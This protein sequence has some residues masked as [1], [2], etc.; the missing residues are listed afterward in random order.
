MSKMISSILPCITRPFRLLTC[1]FLGTGSIQAAE[2]PNIVFILCDDLGY[3]DVGV[4]HQNQRA[5][6]NDRSVP[7]FTT[8]QLDRM[9]GGGMMLTQHYCGA[10][11]CAPSRAT[12]LTGLT[13][14]HANIRDNQFDKALADTH[15]VGTVLRQAGYAT[16]AIGKWGLQG[17]SSDKPAA[18]KPGKGG[19]DNKKAASTGTA[20][21]WPAYPTRRGFDDYF[22]YVRHKD[23][24]FH[25]PKEDGREIWQNDTE[26]SKDLDLCFTTDLFTAQAKKWITDHTRQRAKQ[27][28]FLYLA[29]DTPHAKLQNP[30]CAYPSG[31]GLGGGVQWTGKAH[32]MIN[33]ATGKMDGWMHPDYASAT[34]D[35]DHKPA[36]KE[37]PWPDAQKRYANNV[38]R[39][40]DATGDI[41]SLL[42]DLGIIDNTLVVF[43]SDNGP[44]QESYL[45][46]EPYDPDFFHGFGPFDGVKR[47][48]LEGGMRE[49]TIVHWPD[50]VPAASVNADPSGHWDWLATFAEAA[51]VA[52]P[53]ASDG[54]SL[55]PWLTGRGKRDGGTLYTEYFV[56]GRT[57]GYSA[58]EAAH[59]GRKRNQMQVVFVNGYKGLRYDI[60]SADQDFE[61]HDVTKDP[62][63]ARNLAKSPRFAKLQETMKA[64]ALQCRM[65]SP[66]APRPYDN[67]PVPPSTA[68]PTTPPGVT[69]S[70]Y[71]GKWPWMPDFRALTPSHRG[72]ATT[73]DPSVVTAESPCGVFFEA[74]LLIPADGNYTFTVTSNGGSMLFLHDKRVIDEAKTLTTAPVSGTVPLKSGWHPLRL[75][76]R[77]T[78]ASPMLKFSIADETGRTLV[79]DGRNLRQVGAIRR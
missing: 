4:F 79:L 61:I 10:P 46:N 40:D 62:K 20:L 34:W 76:F 8:P 56:G 55:L 48:T 63:E 3:G 9:A 39:I 42:T 21:D 19:P 58:F 7:F 54:V 65:P 44:S 57:P 29:F 25:Y 77:Q 24:H 32:A 64:R 50:H 11:V 26:V 68:V 27:P 30:P 60:K 53:A 38:R 52:P 66:G 78:E 17:A 47:D 14:G 18:K 72:I 13:Q 75:L 49:P 71:Q 28:F 23:G 5:A 73:I 70:S 15:T 37:V 41:L 43:S 2:R 74:H 12:L 67:S 6:K 69:W 33:T 51:G 59:Q 1:C 16:A 36:T 31:G 35:H 22:G 45:K